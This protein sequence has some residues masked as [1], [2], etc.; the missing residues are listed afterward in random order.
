VK[1]IGFLGGTF[2]PIHFGHIHLGISLQEAHGLDEVIVCPTACSPLKK[3]LPKDGKHRLEMI[4]LAITEIPH[5]HLLD[6]EVKQSPPSYTIDTI[7]YLLKNVY[8]QGDVQMHLLIA[9]DALDN[10]MRWKE[11]QELLEIAPPLIGCR[12]S[13]R[14]RHDFILSSKV[15]A[16]ITNTKVLEISATEIRDRLKKG[17]Y[18][19]HL[20][21]AKVLDYITLHQL[22]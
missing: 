15:Q 9:E 10:L 12:D 22:Y 5:W 11:I 14:Q 18:C 2:D 6:W 13:L 8:H 20:V 16:G 7:R 19:G 21:P 1:H 17:L 4:R 3:S